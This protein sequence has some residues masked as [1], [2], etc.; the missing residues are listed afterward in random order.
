MNK[1]SVGLSLMSGLTIT[2][3]SGFNVDRVYAQAMSITVS[4]MATIAQTKGAQ[5]RASFSVTNNGEAAIRTRIFTQDFDYDPDKGYVKIKD[6]PHSA[7]PYLQF[8]PQELV[9]PPGVTREVRLNITIPPSKP[10][11]EYRVA[12]FTEDLTERE[13]IDPKTKYIM[14]LKPRIGSIFFISKGKNTSELSAVSANWNVESGKPHLV[15][16]NQG[17]ASAYSNIDWKLKQGNVDIASHQ[18]HGLVLQAG[19]ERGTDLAI[20]LT[21]K[22][23]PGNYTLVGDIDNNDGKIVP[24][25]LNVNVPVK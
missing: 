24:F 16:K 5:A 4:P 1:L 10:D 6:H 8:S 21:T 15:L 23:A 18:V 11:G 3:W 2:G 9:I 19:R 17:K 25:S 7:I 14:I 12:V 13:I 20:P 22:I